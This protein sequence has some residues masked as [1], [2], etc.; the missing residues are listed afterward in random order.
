M[1]SLVDE[2]ERAQGNQQS[3]GFW[4]VLHG[5]AE[6]VASG[7]VQTDRNVK[8]LFALIN[9]QIRRLSEGSFSIA[10]RLLRD[11]LFLIARAENPSPRVQQIR[12]AYQLDGLVPP[13]FEKKRYGQVDPLALAVAKEKLAHAKNAWN[14]VAGGD[15]GAVS[16]FDSE[17]HKL[18]EAGAKLHSSPLL[19][20]L[21]EIGGIA[22]QVADGKSAE[23]LGLEMATSLLFIENALNHI[24]HLPDNFS[25]RADAISARL[26][27]VVSGQPPTESAQWLDDMSREAQER[28]TM[29]VL[30]VEL[31]TSLRQVEKMLDEY[32]NHPAERTA[33]AQI[34]ATLHQ[35]GGALAIL[36]Q[37]DAMLA[38][39]H[40]QDAVKRFAERRRPMQR[41][42]LQNFST[43]PAT[44]AH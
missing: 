37:E 10:E 30:A 44:L 16:M 38:I 31:Q 27:S 21:R 28:Q 33:L 39:Q 40:T 1:C 41:R 32:F 17:L 9:L 6:A 4:W 11:A 5:F 23:M 19:K 18:V 34:E 8:Q 35:I 25:E 15:T 26:L 24:G 2:V 22:R 43:L 13:D 36:D 12:Y 29:Q 20:L 7:Q 42:M 3:R 14:R